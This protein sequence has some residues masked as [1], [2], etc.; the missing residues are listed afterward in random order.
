MLKQTPR[1][2]A[3]NQEVLAAAEE[4][5]KTGKS[6]VLVGAPGTGKAFFVDTAVS[7]QTTL[8]F[9]RSLSAYAY[10]LK[11]GRAPPGYLRLMVKSLDEVFGHAKAVRAI[12]GIPEFFGGLSVIAEVCE[13][14]D[15]PQRGGMVAEDFSV[16]VFFLV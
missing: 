13:K 3:P 4:H 2:R 15:K 5:V 14:C 6:I 8:V 12:T 11:G 10:A 9:D 16:P 1:W 7:E